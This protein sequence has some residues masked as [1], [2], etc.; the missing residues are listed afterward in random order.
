MTTPPHHF[1]F[2]PLISPKPPKYL[3]LPPPAQFGQFRE[4]PSVL[5][6]WSWGGPTMVFVCVV[7]FVVVLCLFLFKCLSGNKEQTV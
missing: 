2:K 1:T 5:Y 6:E 3:G 4:S 7:F